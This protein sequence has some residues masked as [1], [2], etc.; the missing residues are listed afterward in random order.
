MSTEVNNL[1]DALPTDV[2]F[3][4]SGEYAPW[5]AKGS[6]SLGRQILYNYF[7]YNSLL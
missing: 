4:T 7:I 5:L 2:V 1:K 3:L 6:R